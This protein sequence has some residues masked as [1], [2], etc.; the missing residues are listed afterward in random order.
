MENL[1]PGIAIG[2]FASELSLMTKLPCSQSK[3]DE[4]GSPESWRFTTQVL[5]FV[6]DHHWQILSSTP[7]AE[8][9]FSLLVSDLRGSN[10]RELLLRV[11]GSWKSLLPRTLEL[12]PLSDRIFLP[13]N[14]SENQGFGWDIQVLDHAQNFYLS[15]VPMLAPEVS[16]A[17]AEDQLSLD[18]VALQKTLRHLLFRSQQQEIRFRFFVRHLPGA[19]FTQDKELGF[20]S[21][22]ETLR[23]LL[24]N[25]L[26]DYVR[27]GKDWLD[28][29]HPSDL[30][31]VNKNLK[32]C[33]DGCV[34]V[35]SR[36]RILVPEDDRLL[37]LMELRMPVRGLNGT[38]SSFE[39][40][41][42]DLTRESI[43]ERRLQQ[44][45]WKASLA[46]ISGSLSHNFNNVLG[47]LCGLSDLVFQ[48]ASPD[49]ESYEYL[50][51]IRE[52]SREAVGL[53]QRIIALNREEWGNIELHDLVKIIR[54]QEE[55]IRIILPKDARFNMQ[56]PSEE[57]PVR[58][59]AVALRRIFVNLS[60]NAR[61]AIGFKGQVD[62]SVSMVDLEDYDRGDLFSSYCPAKGKGVEIVFKDDGGGIDPSILSQIFGPYFST[63]DSVHDS[64]LGLYSLS[65]FARE[66]K[67]DF[68]VR[69]FVGKGT[70]ILL[71]IQVE[72]FD[73]TEFED[74]LEVPRMDPADISNCSVAI[75]G[76]A[77]G[78]L[79]PIVD[80]LE[81]NKFS[82][83]ILEDAA[84]VEAW[85][86]STDDRNRV[87]I[88]CM[89]RSTSPSREVCSSLKLDRKNLLSVLVLK[90]LNPDHFSD[91]FG[92]VFDA[93]YLSSSDPSLCFRRIIDYLEA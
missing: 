44:A 76:K 29:I 71:L 15:L 12:E 69:S 55:L 66:N 57:I 18:P 10:L 25:K 42:L 4:T 40:L 70:E 83:R 22:T 6:L 35:A 17:V 27:E 38:L 21:L 33:R 65:Q 60:T 31:E 64:G 41:W 82:T 8:E 47:G 26:S 3:F 32:L 67:F 14:Q 52:K 61:D 16:P 34:P 28:W 48:E 49:S 80:M 93:C 53:I 73:E 77:S 59:D 81:Y 9:Q 43:A 88:T 30:Q 20:T 84:S 39:C 50:K 7:I 36:F 90:G 91:F 46:E 89:S 19:H 23:K 63:K 78:F 5:H 45:S 11:S 87:L 54:D 58:I 24:G 13:W 68:G 56:L 75:F 51:I 79:Q 72:G 92:T 62:L 1:P 85:L 37:Y 74:D 2:D 86:E